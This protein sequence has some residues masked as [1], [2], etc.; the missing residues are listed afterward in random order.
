MMIYINASMS[1]ECDEKFHK[2]SKNA[3]RL[4]NRVSFMASSDEQKRM[5]LL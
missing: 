4:H 2:N 5:P 3:F 1:I